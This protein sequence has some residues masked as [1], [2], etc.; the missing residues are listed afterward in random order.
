MNIELEGPSIGRMLPGQPNAGAGHMQ[1][2][3]R[4][5]LASQMQDAPAPGTSL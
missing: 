3:R 5:S 2:M 4:G 1:L